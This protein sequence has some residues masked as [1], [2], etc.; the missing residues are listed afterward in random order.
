MNMGYPA[1]RQGIHERHRI[2]LLLLVS[3]LVAGLRKAD[4]GN[5]PGI[6]QERYT[7]LN[8]GYFGPCKN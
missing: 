2:V 7:A 8:T 5:K 4:S 6:I 3:C 1:G